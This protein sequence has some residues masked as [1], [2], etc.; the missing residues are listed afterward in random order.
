MMTSQERMFERLLYQKFH[1][2]G[3]TK[4]RVIHVRILILKQYCA[5]CH[6]WL[7]LNSLKPRSF[8]GII[9]KASQTKFSQIWI[10][11]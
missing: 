7:G 10:T 3:T 1:Q 8:L 5:S 6:Q 4:S 2:N 11:K 9:P